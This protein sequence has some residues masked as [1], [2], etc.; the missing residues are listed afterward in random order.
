MA[1]KADYEGAHRDEYL[2][3]GAFWVP[4]DAC[5]AHLQACAKLPS[6]GKDVDDAMVAI[7]RDNRTDSFAHWPTRSS[8]VMGRPRQPPRADWPRSSLSWA[9]RPL[10]GR[11]WKREEPE[12]RRYLTR[13]GGELGGGKGSH[14]VGSGSVSA[15]TNR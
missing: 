6:I 13:T 11:P 15:V 7:E 5:W 4:K 9:R 14:R 2:A 8:S 12:T 3:A 1:G 10:G